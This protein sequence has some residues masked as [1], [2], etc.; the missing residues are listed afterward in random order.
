MGENKL[1]QNRPAKTDWR[2]SLPLLTGFVF[3]TAAGFF[4]LRAVG[5][6]TLPALVLSVGFALLWLIL[7]VLSVR[8]NQWLP[9]LI[10]MLYWLAA[11][12]VRLFTTDDGSGAREVSGVIEVFTDFASTPLS[13]L[14][15]LQ[16]ELGLLG[17]AG[18]TLAS[19]IALIMILD[20]HK[21]NT[22]L[23]GDS[24]GGDSTDWF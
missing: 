14:N 3:L 2:T 22:S 4:L 7:D 17:M 19:L 11:S 6:Q 5:P 1:K 9:L 21:P 24:S 20:R 8:K 18:L 10:T 23:R 13:G 15:Q 12:L 16:P